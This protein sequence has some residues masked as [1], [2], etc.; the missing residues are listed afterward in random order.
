MPDDSAAPSPVPVPAPS[1]PSRTCGTSA[2]STYAHDAARTSA[3]DGCIDGPLRVA[4]TFAP[5][6][7]ATRRA[8]VEH[9][10]VDTSG[11][12]VKALSGPAPVLH[13]LDDRGEERWTFDSHA[14]VVRATWPT[15]APHTV[16]VNDDGVY[17]I[18]IETG[19]NRGTEIDIWGDSLT[20]GTRFLVTNTWQEDGLGLFVGSYDLSGAPLWKQNKM[21]GARGIAVPNVGGLAL[22]GGALFH[23]ANYGF[24]YRSSI[25]AYD[26]ATGD[27][28]WHVATV[29]QS[30]PSAGDGQ[31]FV[32]ERWG[33]GAGERAR[34]RLV[35]RAQTDGA[36]AW[37]REVEGAR[38]PAPLLAGALVVVH[39]RSGVYAFDRATG[40]PA[41]SVPLVRGAPPD[42]WSTTIAAAMGS[43]TLVVL[44]GD[45]LHVLALSDGAPVWTGSP[46]PGARSLDSPAIFAESLF[47]VAD[48]TL[49]RLDPQG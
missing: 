7:I 39:A 15:I 31:I 10:V 45:A 2:W 44:T 26:P 21:Y 4:W 47:V 30:A 14:D 43:Q 29:P 17:A 37:S 38:G 9:A 48:G 46:K 25:D 24:P 6:P 35:A 22:D 13:A 49:L 12:Y 34:D 36:V 20:D 19:K 28:R 11:V 27:R 3:S 16:L 1:P 41:W 42:S 18:D 40:T 5:K 33:G 23:A 32:I 8:S